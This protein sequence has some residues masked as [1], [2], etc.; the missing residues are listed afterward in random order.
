MASKLEY[1]KRYMSKETADDNT[2]KKKKKK[3]K[4][5]KDPGR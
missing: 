5:D 3:K 1:L 2:G 4:H